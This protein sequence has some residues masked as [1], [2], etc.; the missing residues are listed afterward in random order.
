MRWA[1]QFAAPGLPFC[2][3]YGLPDTI[4]FLP[5]TSKP[6]HFGPR[7]GRTQHLCPIDTSNP[8]PV[9]WTLRIQM[10]GSEVSWV[11]NVFGPKCSVSEYLAWEDSWS[12]ALVAK[13]DVSSPYTYFALSW[14][15]F[16][17]VALM[18]FRKFFL[19]LNS[20]CS[21]ITSSTCYVITVHTFSNVSIWLSSFYS[22]ISFQWT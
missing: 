21:F 5:D 19:Q 4:I 22:G 12:L 7:T 14:V 18:R 16:W 9:W 13:L 2:L 10:F 11:L 15:S 8:P 3:M 6:R 17:G 20:I 1:L